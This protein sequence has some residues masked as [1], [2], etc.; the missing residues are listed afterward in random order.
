MLEI[1]APL[2]LKKILLTPKNNYYDKEQKD[3]SK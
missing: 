1:T 3:Y 2:F